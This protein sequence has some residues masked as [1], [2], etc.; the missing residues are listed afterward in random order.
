MPN[1]AGDGHIRATGFPVIGNEVF[2]GHFRMVRQ[3]GGKFGR[4]GGSVLRPPAGPVRAFRRSAGQFPCRRLVARQRG[5]RRDLC[6]P[7]AERHLRMVLRD[8]V[9]QVDDVIVGRLHFRCPPICSFRSLPVAP[10]TK[11]VPFRMAFFPIRFLMPMI[12]CCRRFSL[13]SSACSSAFCF[14]SAS[15]SVKRSGWLAPAS[16]VVSLSP[17][18]ISCVFEL[19]VAFFASRHANWAGLLQLDSQR[20]AGAAG[21]NHRGGKLAL[22]QVIRRYGKRRAWREQMVSPVT[23]T[24]SGE[25]SATVAAICPGNGKE[26]C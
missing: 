11:F 22:D 4:D 21:T 24:A 25:T 1:P 14:F 8:V 3:T 13:P 17:M 15:E 2:D 20:K 26:K 9:R 18:I 23:T 10:S 5:K 19:F 7:F 6:G 12:A 16:A